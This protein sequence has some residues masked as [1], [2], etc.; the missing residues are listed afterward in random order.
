[1]SLP[2]SKLWAATLTTTLGGTTIT[3]TLRKNEAE[4]EP[5]EW[6]LLVTIAVNSGD[7]AIERV[8]WSSCHWGIEVFQAQDIQFSQGLLLLAELHS[9]HSPIAA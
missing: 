1:M 6:L 4:A 7:D 3:T 5:I 9:R 2:G 8:Q